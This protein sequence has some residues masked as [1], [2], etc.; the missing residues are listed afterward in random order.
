[1]CFLDTSLFWFKYKEVSSLRS[2]HLRV[3]HGSRVG[4][5]FSR[6]TLCCVTNE[7][8]RPASLLAFFTGGNCSASCSESLLGGDH[9]LDAVVHV[10]DEVN[11]GTTESAEVRDVEDAVISLSVLTVGTTDLDVVLVSDGLE[12]I[13]MSAKLRKF[14]VD[15]SAHAGSEVGGA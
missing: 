2:K 10:L 11:L 14:D 8:S 6:I 15:G 3:C 4:R 12:L 7:V 9:G 1:M 13:L 5:I